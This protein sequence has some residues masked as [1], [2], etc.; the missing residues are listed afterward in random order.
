[1]DVGSYCSAARLTALLTD[2]SYQEQLLSRR[3]IIFVN[4]QVY[5]RCRKRF[6]SEDTCVDEFPDDRLLS[7]WGVSAMSHLAA[8]ST[9]TGDLEGDDQ[10]FPLL[11][12]MLEYYS[13]RE[14]TYEK[15]AINAISGILRI[16]SPQLDS[17]FLQGLPIMALDYMILF[18]VC[19]KEKSTSD[20]S[21]GTILTPRRRHCFPSWSWAG[22]EALS[23][24]VFQSDVSP[25]DPSPFNCW[26]GL[27]TWIT[28]YKSTGL[29]T[30]ET[31]LQESRLKG[32]VRSEDEIYYSS[33]S[34]PGLSA[35]FGKLDTQTTAPSALVSINTAY[36]KQDLL[37]FYTVAVTLTIS[38]K[39]PHRVPWP[40]HGF[41]GNILYMSDVKPSAALY[42][43]DGSFSGLLVFDMATFPAE[44]GEHE[45]I[46]LSE[47][48]ISVFQRMDLPD[49][50][51][52]NPFASD[53]DN[54][55][56]WRLYWVLLLTW[57]DGVAERRGIGQILQSSIETSFPPGPQWR[58][59]VLG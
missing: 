6:W 46:L 22:W 16:I 54:E 19:E 36:L 11:I 28:W 45:L 13:R 30:P 2:H 8:H 17:E 44:E 57:N 59:I 37:R 31:I 38:L 12:N 27:R 3:T 42:D 35:R 25:A 23:S 50:Q 58:E 24:W 4:K 39:I 15:D 9:G 49:P 10:P 47:S 56:E 51:R 41:D 48:Q 52:S 14:L 21:P 40:A 53:R 1:M 55:Q 26:L 20:R 29:E 5:F 18:Q 7:E 32:R 43:F 34:P 33:A